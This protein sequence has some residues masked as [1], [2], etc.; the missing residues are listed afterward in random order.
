MQL[1]IEQLWY[2][3]K[4]YVLFVLAF[5]CPANIYMP[6]LGKVRLGR[7]NP[8]PFQRFYFY[9]RRKKQQP[10]YSEF[11]ALQHCAVHIPI[12]NFDFDLFKK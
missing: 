8:T 7:P 6:S 12:F 2:R 9:L 1:C 3:I 11:Y 10:F 4:L 5:F